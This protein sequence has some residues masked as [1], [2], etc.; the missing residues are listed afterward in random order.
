MIE[1][2]GEGRPLAIALDGR[3]SRVRLVSLDRAV[4]ELS[5]TVLATTPGDRASLD[6]YVDHT[7]VEVF[8]S[9][10]ESLTLRRTATQD[11][12]DVRM[13]CWVGTARLHLAQMS[14]L[15]RM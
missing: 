5:T 1:D 10:G 4:E 14:T 6:V 12:A 13:T 3:G 8:A 2:V 7:I 11:S 15:R 9:T